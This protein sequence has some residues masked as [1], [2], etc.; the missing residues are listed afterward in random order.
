MSVVFKTKWKALCNKKL[1]YDFVTVQD[2]AFGFLVLENNGL[3]YLDMMINPNKGKKDWIQPKYTI[4]NGIHKKSKRGWS[5]DGRIRFMELVE[6]VEER[7]KKDGITNL[8]N[9]VLQVCRE[10]SM[11]RSAG[12]EESKK[13]SAEECEKERRWKQFLKESSMKRY[14][15]NNRKRDRR[16]KSKAYANSRNNDEDGGESD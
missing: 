16:G 9:Y 12:E 8:A 3:R 5:L 11:K 14:S 1:Y 7:R 10:K 4:V 13:I 6:E 15:L 2:E